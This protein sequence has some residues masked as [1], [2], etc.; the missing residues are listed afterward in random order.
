M[1]LENA[2]QFSSA[3]I[4]DR[5][6]VLIVP[7]WWFENIISKNADHRGMDRQMALSK[8]ENT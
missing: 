1:R 8:N 4:N 5:V 6:A 2:V 7:D 3:Q